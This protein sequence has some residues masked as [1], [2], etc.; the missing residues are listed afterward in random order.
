MMVDYQELMEI[1]S[2]PRPNAS[3]AEAKTRLALQQW[4]DRQGI[5]YLVHT[6]RIYPYFFEC[7]GIWLM[8]SRTVL[9]VAVWYR[10]GWWSLPIALLGALGGTL[11]YAQNTPL[12]TWP[13]GRLG[14][15][16]IIQFGPDQPLREIIFSAHY[17]T[18]TELLDHMT[19]MFFLKR[20]LFGIVLTLLLGFFGPFENW[21][22]S[23]PT[24]SSE[25]I[26]AIHLLGM[27]LTIS[28]LCLAWGFGLHL[29]VGRILEPSQG[30]VDNGAA[31]AILLGF[32]H[33][34]VQDESIIKDTQVTISLFTGEEVNMQGSRAYVHE[35]AWPI[36]AAA[37]NL[38][39]MAQDG[40]YVYWEADGN[41]FRLQPTSGDLNREYAKAVLQVLGK[42]AVPTGPINSD[43]AS[44]LFAGNPTTT[45]GTRD[46]QFGL[47]GFHRPT[48][49]F[50]RVVMERLPEGVEVRVAF[51]KTW[52]Q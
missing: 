34:L 22:M 26:N 41:V 40:D 24:I 19:R 31:C 14:K 45:I 42:D 52:F 37:L 17:D 39:I 29:V 48:D 28:M 25:F 5:P 32:A 50:D 3:V 27:I 21:L 11:D 2:I 16:I 51:L 38:E 30:A 36:P 6:F 46:T 49:N 7:I 44:F 10:W 18:K 13:G 33:R 43:G 15:N 47:T 1:L 12:V 8:L 23:T 9:A 35:R 4:L 20:L